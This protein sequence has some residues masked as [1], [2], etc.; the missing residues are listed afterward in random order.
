LH[1]VVYGL[2]S[3]WKCLLSG[4]GKLIS[5]GVVAVR[6]LKVLLQSSVLLWSFVLGLLFV[7]GYQAILISGTKSNATFATVKH[8][9]ETQ[10]PQAPPSA[11]QQGVQPAE[12][13][14]PANHAP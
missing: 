7:L 3:R 14:R 11:G 9:G 5:P 2:K 12:S 6:T 13:G 8:G 1:F 10:K 4:A